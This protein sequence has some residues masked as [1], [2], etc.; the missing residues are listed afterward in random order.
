MTLRTSFQSLT[1][2]L[3]ELKTTLDDHLPLFLTSPN[4]PP[5]STPLPKPLRFA[6]THFYATVRL[7][8]GYTAVALALYIFYLDYYL[9]VSWTDHKVVTAWVVLAYAI[10]NAAMTGWTWSMERGIVFEGTRSS[11][12]TTN[13]R[14]YSLP[15]HRKYEPTYRL[16]V[17]WTKNGVPGRKELVTP[18]TLFYQGDGTFVSGEFERWLK[19][20][21]PEVFPGNA[22]GNAKQE[23][24]EGDVIIVDTPSKSTASGNEPVDGTPGAKKRSKKRG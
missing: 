20:Q 24:E 12:D 14:M 10:L 1:L 2:S 23:L 18:F 6:E 13:L 8:L 21:L 11:K 7:A 22:D 9:K 3:L 15:P 19:G 17:E 5:L 16:V 4:L